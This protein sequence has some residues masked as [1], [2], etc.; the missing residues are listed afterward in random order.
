MPN[1]MRRHSPCCVILRQHRTKTALRLSTTSAVPE[2][3]T[4]GVL[5]FL[6]LQKTCLITVR[7]LARLSHSDEKIGGASAALSLCGIDFIVSDLLRFHPKPL[8][9]SQNGHKS[10][11]LLN[12]E[13][14]YDILYVMKEYKKYRIYEIQI[15][16]GDVQNG[17]QT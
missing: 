9:S 13:Q 12:M 5:F 14:K 8:P 2:G 3:N 17:I 7:I 1:Q 6:I 15:S 11:K 16:S 4:L 10:N